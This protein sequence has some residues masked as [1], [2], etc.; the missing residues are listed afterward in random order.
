MGEV[1][2]STMRWT[3]K[4][5]GLTGVATAAIHLGAVGSSGRIVVPLCVRCFVPLTG[6]STLSKP[7]LADLKSGNLYVNVETR[8]NPTGEIRGQL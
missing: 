8:K 4:F 1:A 2:G 3:L 5:T 6:T 7:L